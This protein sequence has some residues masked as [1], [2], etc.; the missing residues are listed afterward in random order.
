V[1]I[2]VDDHTAERPLGRDITRW[3]KAE[4]ERLLALRL[5]LS[6]QYRTELAQSIG[7]DLETLICAEP[8]TIV[9]VYWPIRAEPDLRPWMRAASARGIRI[10]LPIALAVGQPL[11]FRE[12]RP[13][14]PMVRGL[15][16]IPYPAEGPQITPQVLVAPLV[17]FDAA[18]YRLGYGGG[19]FDRTLA[20]IGGDPR[21]IGVGFPETSIPT[22]FPQ[23]HDIPMSWIVTGA[24]APRRR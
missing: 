15:W 17:G 10:A 9:S 3:R 2:P 16:N 8:G 5:N 24:G 23:A 11:V 21:V 19:F 1:N 7:N 18:C 6:V 12:W 22:I 13:D 4:R 20:S 14:A